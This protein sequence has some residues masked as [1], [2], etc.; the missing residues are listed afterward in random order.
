MKVV[1]FTTIPLGLVYGEW[2][3][4]AHSEFNTPSFAVAMR[5]FDANDSITSRTAM[6]LGTEN[7]A[8]KACVEHP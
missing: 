2:N 7:A 4:Y 5:H 6:I 3:V 8:T 1:K